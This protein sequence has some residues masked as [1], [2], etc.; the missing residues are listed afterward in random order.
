MSLCR[1]HRTSGLTLPKM[2]ILAPFTSN[3]WATIVFTLITI[4][5]TYVYFSSRRPKGF[6]PGPPVLPIVGSLP[7]WTTKAEEYSDYILRMHQK[8][9]DIFSV[10]MGRM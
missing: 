8:Y 6:P 5:L 1:F 4:L 7:F 3:A 2:E 10:K 9:G